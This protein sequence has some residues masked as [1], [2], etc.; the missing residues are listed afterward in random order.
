M[1]LVIWLAAAAGYLAVA[2]TFARSRVR[3]W[4]KV[5]PLFDANDGVD[6]GAYALGGLALGLIWPLTLGFLAVRD[7]LWRPVDRDIARR[8]QM[9][10][11]RDDWRARSR[12]A[13]DE[14]E[15]KTAADIADTLDDLL[16]AGGSQ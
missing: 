10:K 3:H 15:R 8:E 13:S 16:R 11:D 2:V 12:S 6:R 14:A 4:H 1:T 5:S 9:S 7:W